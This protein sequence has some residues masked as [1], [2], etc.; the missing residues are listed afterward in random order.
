MN[1]KQVY[2]KNTGGILLANL[3]VLAIG[4]FSRPFVARFLGPSEY[5]IYALIL[6][7]AALLPVLL[8]FSMNIGVLFYSAKNPAREAVKK[9]ISSSTAFVVITASVFFIPVYLISR[10][11]MEGTSPEL[12][13]VSYL[14]AICLSLL[15][16]SQ[17]LQ[18]GTQRFK[19]LALANVLSSLLTAVFAVYLAYSTHSAILIGL[20]RA[21]VTAAISLAVFKSLGGFGKPNFKTLAKLFNYSKFLGA[22]GILGFPIGVIDRYA[23]LWFRTKAEIGYYDIA[24]VLGTMILPF[25]SSF[26]TTMSPAIIRNAEKAAVYY[27]RILAATIAL[28]TT[29]SIAVFYLSDS[30][31]TVLL[32][33]AYAPSIIPL[34]IISVA[35]PAMAL[36][37]L[38]ATMFNSLNKTKVAAALNI[39]LSLSLIAANLLLVPSLGAAGASYAILASFGLTSA[40]GLIYLKRTYTFELYRPA[41]QLV[42]FGVTAT[43]YFTLQEFGF[44]PKAGIVL[45]FTA[46]TILL[47]RSIAI[48]VAENVQKI[49][50]SKLLPE[51]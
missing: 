23:L 29:F 21:A 10:V 17:A 19:G 41:L 33:S 22:S 26:L 14:L 15:Y 28:L 25:I 2:F 24:N 7:T 31:V 50:M 1:E 44:L 13:I 9:I 36:F 45:L 51:N 18:Q 49:V 43:A 16:I 3:A 48:E 6:S 20:S 5:G 47:N 38:N 35:L 11:V 42:I 40:L 32:G 8:L 30:I 46:A 37:S 39:I 27:E 4:F 34:K 12:F